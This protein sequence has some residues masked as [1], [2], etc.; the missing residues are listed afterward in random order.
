MV[1]GFDLRDRRKGMEDRNV[2]VLMPAEGLDDKIQG[3]LVVL[4]EVVR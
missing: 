3:F 1:V 4:R 2:D